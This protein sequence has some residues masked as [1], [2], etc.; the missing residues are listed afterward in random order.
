M[1]KLQPKSSAKVFPSKTL[2]KIDQ[3]GAPPNL[4]TRPR[5][6]LDQ[7]PAIP[8]LDILIEDHLKLLDDPI[9]LQGGE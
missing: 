3:V 8:S 2:H 4:E 1:K 6:S 5:L 7:H 9:P